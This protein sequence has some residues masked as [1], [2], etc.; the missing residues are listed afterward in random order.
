M[1][2]DK[3]AL[4]PSVTGRIHPEA[5]LCKLFQMYFNEAIKNISKCAGKEL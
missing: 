5:L 4:F 1:Q 3:Q 2:E